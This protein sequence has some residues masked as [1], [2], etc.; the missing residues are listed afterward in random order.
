MVK[1]QALN[2]Q[3]CRKISSTTNIFRLIYLPFKSNCLPR[4][5]SKKRVWTLKCNVHYVTQGICSSFSAVTACTFNWPMI[6]LLWNKDESLK[7]IASAFKC[8][9][10]IKK[11]DMASTVWKI[12]MESK[13]IAY[14][15]YMDN[16]YYN[17]S[18]LMS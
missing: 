3:L 12:P 11:K 16:G 17:M 15:K 14:E 1:L 9:W 2:L 4:K 10:S 18:L 13:Y 6:H 5:T 8:D 7:W